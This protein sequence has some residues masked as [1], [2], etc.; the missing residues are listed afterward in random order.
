MEQYTWE[1]KNSAEHILRSRLQQQRGKRQ[2]QAPEKMKTTKH[3][4]EIT[5]TNLNTE[6]RRRKRPKGTQRMELSE[7]TT[8]A[9]KK[10]KRSI[11]HPNN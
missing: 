2:P 9:T 3:T 7:P 4:G 6:R 10:G 1:Q 11:R 5:A 8:A